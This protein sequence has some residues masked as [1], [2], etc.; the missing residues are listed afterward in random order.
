MLL[1]KVIN[2]L[3]TVNF[4]FYCFLTAKNKYQRKKNNLWFVDGNKIKSTKNIFVG[5]KK[6]LKKRT[7][8]IKKT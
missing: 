2:K 6:Y 7:K 5:F 3:I 1:I 4:I 8:K